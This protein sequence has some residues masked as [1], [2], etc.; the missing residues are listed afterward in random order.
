MS[1]GYT[2][3]NPGDNQGPYGQQQPYGS[4]YGHGSGEQPYGAP[5]GQQPP[6][7]YGYGYPPP[8]Q[9]PR[10]H[11][12]VAL[13]ISIVLAL[14][15]YI[16]PGGIAGA[17]MSGIALGQVDTQPDKARNLLKWTWISIGINVALVIV[18]FGVIIAL[19]VSGN[20]D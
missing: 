11:A 18:G 19:G 15:C 7:G 8:Q 5:Y 9:G 20:L 12:I 1:S 6:P 17:I 14:S 16:T 13:V 4:P 2:P 3:E 10:T